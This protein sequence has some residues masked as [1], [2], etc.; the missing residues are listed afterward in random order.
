MSTLRAGD[1]IGKYELLHPI[2]EGGMGEVWVGRL[3]SLGGFESYVAIKVIHGRFA[4]EKRFRDMFLDE[5][6][7]SAVISHPNVVSTQ[8]LGVEGEMLYQV[9][10]YVD[11]DSLA[12][13]QSDMEERAER[14]PL[15]VALRI[16]AD[17][18]SGLHAAHE[19]L[20][21]DG[22]HAEI[23]HRDVSPQNVLLGGNGA[24]K[25]I[26][27]GVA[28]MQDRLAEDSQGTLKGKLRYM[29]PEQAKGEKVDR[30]ADI[31]SIGAVLY[32]MVSG[33]LPFDDR[34]EA[35]YFRS[36]IQG[37]PPAPLPEDVPDDV[38]ELVLKAMA[39]ERENRFPTAE[40][41]AEELFAILRKR[42]ANVA[43]FVEIHLS[44][45][46][47]KRREV[48][49][50]SATNVRTQ[51]ILSVRVAGEPSSS[52]GNA[53]NVNTADILSV[54]RAG[55]VSVVSA[56]NA[57]PATEKQRI[58]VTPP[59]PS[60][61][62]E[63]GV[64]HGQKTDVFGDTVPP[65]PP[66]DA[67]ARSRGVESALPEVPSLDLDLDR[68]SNRGPAPKKPAL[69]PSSRTAPSQSAPS[70]PPAHQG[71]PAAAPP[72][73]RTTT[74]L[75]P[76]ARS[77]RAPTITGTHDRGAAVAEA[78]RAED[79]AATAK[80]NRIVR[81]AFA[82]VGLVAAVVVVVV[83][84]LP[85]LAKRKIVQAAAERGLELE[86]PR[87]GVGF[88][89][90]ELFDVRATGPGLP[91]KTATFASVK[92]SFGGKVSVRGV[93]SVLEGPATELPAALT[94]LA[95][96]TGAFELDVS[97]GRITW[98]APL[99]KGTVVEAKDVRLAFAREEGESDIA[100]VT[101]YLSD[102]FVTTPRG[103]AGPFSLNVDESE[104]RKR[105]RFVF[106]PRN[107]D[108]PNV[109][110]IFGGATAP[111]HVTVR[112]PK[113]KLSLLHV[114]PSYLGLRPADDPE[115]DALVSV[116]IEPAG[117]LKGDGKVAISNFAFGGSPTPTPLELEFALAGVP[118][119][120]IEIAKG[121]ATYGPITADFG[122]L[123]D[124]DPVKGD[125]RFVSK[126]LPCS[127]FVGA[128]AKKSLGVVGA[129]ALDLFGKAIRVTGA[130]N[131]RGSYSFA[132]SDMDASKLKFEVRDTCG[133]ALFPN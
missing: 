104:G 125:I 107:V 25:L 111:T 95:S 34:T 32:E 45:R 53:P 23:V 71:A 47:R 120:P 14:M 41:M 63:G 117:P 10:E 103:K 36:V 15:P 42:P 27:F 51:D 55:D 40:Q 68:G 58:V 44:S 130:V 85:T 2:G 59:S 114:P 57:A 37:D 87:T 61:F 16:A 123:V 19:L 35:L 12:A 64:P 8:D 74:L 28:L 31:Y 4:Q 24:V 43:S 129:L 46:A 108:G 17:V 106:E 66:P 67:T 98:N 84:S 112:I 93:E 121:T 109:F 86:I 6:R 65:P 54:R 22:R 133:V 94:K 99:G 88:S 126:S 50:S 83:L 21:P 113:S 102:I 30:R 20:L 13:I 81:R 89:G 72:T 128:Q 26:D 39:V 9:M 76:E 91:L 77:A 18:C 127:Y 118:N 1:K 97:E 110:V 116:A 69:A 52:Q 78:I 101:A 73:S 56:A 119:K 131:V 7:V 33:H 75:Q 29:P 115:L 124:R 70:A 11:G 3:R 132:L 92:V 49:R 5:A 38:R 80:A 82:I 100:N 96:G 105:A 48:V 62:A 60:T 79:D 122:G 90:V